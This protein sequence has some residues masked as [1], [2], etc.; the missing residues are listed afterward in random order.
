MEA[1][2][3][4][5]PVG[6]ALVLIWLTYLNISY[7]VTIVRTKKKDPTLESC[8][9]KL[10]TFF[11]LGLIIIY[12]VSLVT[13]IIF[14]ITLFLRKE[15][16]LIYFILNLITIFSVAVSYLLQHIIFVGNR[17]MLIGNVMLDYRKIK[18]VTFPKETKLRFV[19][20]QKKYQTSL[21]F[22]NQSKLKKALQKAR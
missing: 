22:I 5:L 12:V 10:G 9:H 18:R 21:W 15:D 1:I 2:L 4:V 13:S 8:L 11:Y 19:Y 16:N 17:Q 7:G 20:G 14:I 6:V 3:G